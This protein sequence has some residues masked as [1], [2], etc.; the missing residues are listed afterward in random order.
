MAGLTDISQVTRP[1][2]ERIAGYQ[3]VEETEARLGG[4]RRAGGTLQGYFEQKIVEEKQSK[5]STLVDSI[6]K[7]GG[8]PMLKQAWPKLQKAS[9][10]YLGQ[11]DFE[12]FAAPIREKEERAYGLKEREIGARE[13]SAAAS[14]LGAKTGEK[15]EKRLKGAKPPASQ[16]D[17][18]LTEFAKL[19]TQFMRGES[20]SLED[21]T[22]YSVLKDRVYKGNQYSVT[23]TKEGDDI[24]TYIRNK[25]T[26]RVETVVAPRWQDKGKTEK[27]LSQKEE[28]FNR[29]LGVPPLERTDE[30]KKYIGTYIRPTAETRGTQKE[31][32]RKELEKLYA[33]G[34]KITPAEI[35]RR[36]MLETSVFP[37]GRLDVTKVEKGDNIITQIR[38]RV[39]GRIKKVTA[40]RWADKD[41]PEEKLTQTDRD[42]QA[43]VGF[44]KRKK[45]GDILSFDDEETFKLLESRF[46]KKGG[47]GRRGRTKGDILKDITAVSM[48]INSLKRLQEGTN[49]TPEMIDKNPILALLADSSGNFDPVEK[50]RTL[51]KLIDQLTFH[52]GELPKPKELMSGTWYMER[53]ARILGD[54]ATREQI[55]AEAKRSAADDKRRIDE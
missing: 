2:S 1:M 4:M 3:Q 35:A 11:I 16:A 29:I 14:M 32:D 5:M 20:V 15:K 51:N 21:T 48:K 44:L 19:H 49:I 47:K 46:A 6:L 39:T 45:A 12:S 30:E 25:L 54:T 17:K 26:N 24:V 9:P 38:D 53:A 41:T 36:G 10:D 22:R 27:T 7:I 34:A 31:R 50:N 55:I 42:R 8:T 43:Y 40:P 23:E 52:E 37:G 33:K 18:E 28:E 13:T